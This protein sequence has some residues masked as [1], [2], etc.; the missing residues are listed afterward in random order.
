MSDTYPNCP[1]CGKKAVCPRCGENATYQT[2]FDKVFWDASAH[3]WK[4]DCQSAALKE[5]EG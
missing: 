2:P 5:V 3:C 4:C 1:D